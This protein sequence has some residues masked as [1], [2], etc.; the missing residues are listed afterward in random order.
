MEELVSFW[1]SIK[2]Y[3]PQY[4]WI[5]IVLILLLTFI[6]WSRKKRGMALDLQYWKPHVVL[7]SKRVWIL[8]IPIVLISLLLATILANPQIVTRTSS[9]IQGKPV[10][11]VVD[12]SASMVSASYLS[13][14]ESSR[15][16]ARQVFNNL[17]ALRAD[18]NFGLM[19]YASQNYVARHFTYKNELFIDTLENQ[20]ELLSIAQQT[21]TGEALAS[22]NQFLTNNIKGQDKAII[23]I[24]DLDYNALELPIMKEEIDAILKKGIKLYIISSNG[25]E[26]AMARIPKPEGAQVI[27]SYDKNSINKMYEELIAMQTSIIRTDEQLS[28]TNCIP[29]IIPP[30]LGTMIICFILSETRFIKIP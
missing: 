28:K 2:F 25:D 24:S 22:A 12:A 30:V 29:V 4:F 21:R 17:I 13:P 1:D 19:I 10:M 18:L 15:D 14:K 26:E 8:S 11:A 6:P 5:A 3:D 7:N 9:L 20:D 23:L 16:T 27:S